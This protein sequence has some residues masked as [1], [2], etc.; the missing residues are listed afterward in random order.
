[1]SVTIFDYYEKSLEQLHFVP[2]SASA[3]KDEVIYKMLT[4]YGRGTL[5]K[6]QVNSM[7]LILIGDFTPKDTFEK[8]SVVDQEYIEISQFETDTSSFKVGGR[9]IEQVDQGICCYLNHS[10]SVYVSCE[11]GKPIRFTKV[12]LTRDYLDSYLKERCGKA[13]DIS[14]GAFDL[15]IKNP[16]F[17]ELNFVF[18]Q[19]KDCQATDLAA[20]L[21]LESKVMEI[22]SLITYSK[23]NANNRMP[24]HVK[25]DR[26][27][28]RSLNKAVTLMKHNLSSYPSIKEMAKTCG[29][30][31][32]RFQLAF[33]QV[34]GST[35]YEY[36]KDMKMNYALFLL[37]NS[38]YSIQVVA[39]K[40]GY[41]NAGHF[42]GIFKKTYGM[43]P[44]EYRNIHRIK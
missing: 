12:I 33:K 16:N 9:K 38:D 19:M 10:K 27:D 22:L 11:A 43:S 28:L 4:E 36:F 26:R 5:K 17:P 23:E 13:Y 6:I 18:Q 35:A 2:I 39:L 40:V 21:Y 15:L 30:S 1:M 25:V 14:E 31:I 42:A 7:F 41:T 32:S 20:Q 8:V 44:K 24:L 3:S 29:M 34:Y 37:Q